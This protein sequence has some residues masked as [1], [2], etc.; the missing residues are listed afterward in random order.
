MSLK[1]KLLE[2][3]KY[4]P[5][6]DGAQSFNIKSALNDNWDKIEAWAQSVKNALAKPDGEREDAG[7]GCDADGGRHQNAQQRRGRRGG[8]GKAS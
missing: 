2:L 7:E 4:E 8:Y 6:K 5:D 1:T 3:F